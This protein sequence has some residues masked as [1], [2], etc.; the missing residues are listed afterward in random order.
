MSD[1]A[2]DRGKFALQRELHEL[3]P[4]LSIGPKIDQREF[5]EKDTVIA[6]CFSCF[7]VEKT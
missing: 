2:F 4:N 6:P 3:L 1:T 7:A 5:G